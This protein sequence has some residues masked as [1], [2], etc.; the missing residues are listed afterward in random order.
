MEPIKFEEHIREKLQER[1]ISP[2]IKSW[3]KL[4]KHLENSNPN[5]KTNKSLWFAIAAGFIGIIIVTSFVLNEEFFSPQF[6]PKLVEEIIPSDVIT[7]ND[8]KENIVINDK[9]GTKDEIVEMPK[10]KAIKTIPPTK[11]NTIAVDDAIAVN[12]KKENSFIEN[13]PLEDAISDEYISESKVAIEN[14]S[15]EVFINS[16]VEEVVA[17]VQALQESDNTVSAEE[18][19]SLLLKAQDEIHSRE[20]ISNKKVDATALLNMVESE[21]ETNFRDKVFEALGD[22]YEKVRT[23]VVERNN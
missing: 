12:E 1:E 11:E 20:I 16:K 5:K 17:Q 23:A 9:Q 15:E 4:E 6:A 18:I 19:N 21:L 2:S 13:T 10:E 14:S 22:G 8:N 7:P 3:E